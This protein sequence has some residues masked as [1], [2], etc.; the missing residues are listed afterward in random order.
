ML[1]LGIGTDLTDVKRLK[2][3]MLRLDQLNLVGQMAAGISHEVRNP[4]TT[5]R[6]FL[7]MLQ[8][9]VMGWRLLYRSWQ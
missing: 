3:E 1:R 7:Q 9:L 2:N 4:M 8:K 5:V 6:G